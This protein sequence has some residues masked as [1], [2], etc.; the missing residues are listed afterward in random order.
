MPTA[1]DWMTRMQH[2]TASTSFRARRAPTVA[3]DRKAST[4]GVS[5]RVGSRSDAHCT[6]EHG[7][8]RSASVDHAV[9]DVAGGVNRWLQT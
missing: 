6:A 3:A 8:S 9:D 7:R 2:S 1:C 5:S 4:V